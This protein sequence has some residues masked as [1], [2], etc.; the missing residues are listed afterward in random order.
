MEYTTLGRTGLNVSRMGLGC[1][2][3]SR[4]GMQTGRTAADAETVVREALALGVNFIDSAEAYGTEEIVGRAIAGTPRDQV[5]LSTKAGVKRD[6]RQSTAAEYRGRVEACLRRLGTDYI[7][8]FHVHGVAV[9]DYA[10]A[11][12]ELAPVLAAM[13]Q[14][15]RVRFIGITETFGWDPSHA[16]L[17]QAIHDP[18]WDVMMVGFNVLNQSARERVLAST[19]RQDVGTLCMFAVRRALTRPEVLREQV[20]ELIG[21]GLVDAAGLDPD[22]PLGF[23]VTEGGAESV[24]DAA[25]R[26]C[27]WEPGLDVILSG[28]SSVEHLREN[29]ASL[30]RGPLPESVAQRLRDLFARV[31]SVSGN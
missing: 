31:D 20:L 12:D 2:G 22:D 6:D 8:V 29:A 16:M 9:A 23:V 4:L 17:Q 26:F 3:P 15:G 18:V 14:E 19:Q 13:R 25:Y 24:T 10:Y 27:R 30:A 5:I 1:G 28:T 7:D 11:R 21:K